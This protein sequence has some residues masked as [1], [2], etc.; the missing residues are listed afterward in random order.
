MEVGDLIRHYRKNAEMTQIEL[1]QKAGVAISSL[2]LYE[3]NKRQPGIEQ[4]K[5][6]AD[7]LKISPALFFADEN[8]RPYKLQECIVDL[9]HQIYGVEGEGIP[10]LED[11]ETNWLMQILYIMEKYDDGKIDIKQALSQTKSVILQCF[12]PDGI[13]ANST[14]EHSVKCDENLNLAKKTWSSEIIDAIYDCFD[15]KED[16]ERVVS[17]I[18]LATVQGQAPILLQSNSTEEKSVESQK[19]SKLVEKCKALDDLGIEKVLE[20][21]EMLSDSPKYQRK[22]E[23]EDEMPPHN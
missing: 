9:F 1:S 10:Y 14:F 4:L 2:R 5:C 22:S 21:V 3:A 8:Q 16:F 13:L 19:I 18:S 17:R 7:V 15:G 6:I 11:A 20:Y 12:I 23:S